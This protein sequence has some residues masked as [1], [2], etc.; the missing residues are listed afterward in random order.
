MGH[1][2][3][4]SRVFKGLCIEKDSQNNGRIIQKLKGCKEKNI[5]ISTMEKFDRKEKN[6]RTKE[7]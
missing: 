7:G 1:L 4:F 3:F 2:S 5:R 6:K